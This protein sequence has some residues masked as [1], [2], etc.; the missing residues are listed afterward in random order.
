MAETFDTHGVAHSGHGVTQ[1]T[2]GGRLRVAMHLAGAAISLGLVVGIAIWGYRIMVRDVTGIPVVRAVEGPM[3]VQPENPGGDPADHQGLAVNAVAADGTAAP[4][5]D[6]L[7]LAPRPVEL[8]DEDLPKTDL[9]QQV[10]AEVA[11]EA[12]PETQSEIDTLI[13]ELVTSQAEGAEPIV[14]PAP[15]VFEEVTQAAADL[16]VGTA[17]APALSNDAPG[18]A[19]SLRP[20]LR[21]ASAAAS[22]PER[23]MTASA[24]AQVEVAPEDVPVGTRVVQFGAFDTPDV[25]RAEWDRLNARF[26][27]YL[28]GKSRIVQE[29]SSGGRTFYRLRAMGFADLSDARRFCSAL[30]A[31]GADCI[32][33]VTR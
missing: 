17:A 26:A 6:R 11:E 30:V 22:G 13:A 12:A 24:P 31:E 3:R 1:A 16:P 20:R 8:E 25:A 10:V 23:V 19:R 4:P 27:E 5:A 9:A 15:L 28:A 18:V 2:L 21:P 32:P 33:V 7:V 14:Q 29:A